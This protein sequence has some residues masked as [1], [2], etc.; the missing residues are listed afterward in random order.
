MFKNFTSLLLAL[1]SLLFSLNAYPQQQ[2]AWTKSANGLEYKKIMLSRGA[3]LGKELLA[4][5]ISARQGIKVL[6]AQ[7]FGKRSMSAREICLAA[8]A[9]LCINSSFFDEKN[10]ALGLLISSGITFQ[11]THSGGE[12]L[13]GIFA[14]T[15]K[16]FLILGRDDFNS[17]LL[18]EAV[19]AGPRLVV[20]G[21]ALEDFK[22]KE[23]SRRSGICIDNNGV[24]VFF[25]TS[26]DS[27]AV[28][29][30]DFAQAMV[31]PEVNCKDGL[32][33]D[34]G[35]SAQLFMR[36]V[37]GKPMAADEALFDIRGQDE[38]PVFLAVVEGLKF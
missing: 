7:D 31:M 14:S 29:L 1:S 18:I 27:W 23:V 16:S 25:A 21:K 12:T 15:R 10:N 5:K 22:D 6:R 3:S 33:L 11:K 36:T 24:P 34:G 19:Q 32:N 9:L 30:A 17:A 28:S 2:E 8:G 20:N 35:G 38:A 37:S 26:N 4:V 13:T